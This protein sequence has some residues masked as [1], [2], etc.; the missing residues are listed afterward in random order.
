MKEEFDALGVDFNTRGKRFDEC[1][2]VLRELWTGKMVEHHGTFFDFPRVQLR[3]VP[4]QP[5]PIYVGG[6]TP[7]ALRRA[8][9]LGDGWVGAG[10]SVEDALETVARLKQLLAEAGRAHQPFE[11]VMPIPG[12]PPD[13]DGLKR[14]RDAGIGS[15]LSYPFTLTIGPTS[16]V[17]Q[18]RAY[19]ENYAANV[20]AKLKR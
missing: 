17:G 5:V 7:A 10:Q 16:T 20:I 4:R 1:V 8:A 6:M 12:S 14:L 15:V 13:L 3:P 18:K 11:M 19:L 9:R 2:G